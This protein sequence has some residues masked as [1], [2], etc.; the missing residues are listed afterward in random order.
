MLQTE[1]RTDFRGLAQLGARPSATAY[2]GIDAPSDAAA[3]VNYQ[4]N[5]PNVRRPSPPPMVP[6]KVNPII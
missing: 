6:G 5:R 4:A 2:Q 1:V 3:S